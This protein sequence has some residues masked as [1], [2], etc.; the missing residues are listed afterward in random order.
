MKKSLINHS[1]AATVSILGTRSVFAKKKKCL[2]KLEPRVTERKYE[3]IHENSCRLIIKQR[4]ERS[5]YMYFRE[6][7][8]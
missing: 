4:L 8:S 2:R 5:P 3:S 1:L 6:F 7:G